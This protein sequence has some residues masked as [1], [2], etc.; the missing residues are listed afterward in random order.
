[1]IDLLILL[2]FVAYAVAA[3]FRARRKA[4]ENL[5]EYFLA[6]R[7]L[8]GWQAGLSTAATQFAADTPLLVTGLV[9]TG[10][11]FLLWR[12]WIYGLAFLLM[13]FV[14]AAGWRRA[15][16]LT[17]AE[18]TEVRYGG[19]G[20]LALRVLKAVYC[21]PGAAGAD[22]PWTPGRVTARQSMVYCINRLRRFP[23]APSWGTSPG[24]SLIRWQLGGSLC[25][26]GRA[27]SSCCGCPL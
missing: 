18:L 4:S 10:G 17:D 23:H 7:T 5:H 1:M 9:A 26:T 2:A 19:R 20:A 16:L 25:I 3:G 11:I 8:R 14:F 24:T 15:G 27:G 12:L 13:A 22:R 21:R 6:G